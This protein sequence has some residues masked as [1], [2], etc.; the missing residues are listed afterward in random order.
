LVADGPLADQWLAIAQAFAG[1]PG[2]GRVAG[3]FAGGQR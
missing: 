2:G 3:Q 1:P